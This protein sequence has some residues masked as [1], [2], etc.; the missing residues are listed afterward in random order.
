MKFTI[1]EIYS[2]T[3]LCCL[4]LFGVDKLSSLT[5]CIQMY[6]QEIRKIF[7]VQTDISDTNVEVLEREKIECVQ[8]PGLPDWK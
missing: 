1:L 8:V 3:K 6:N 7:D 2:K 5:A 4:L